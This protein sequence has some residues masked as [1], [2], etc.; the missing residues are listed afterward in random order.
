METM[1]WMEKYL[2]E[3]EGLII[4]GQTDEGLNILNSLLYEE[5]GYGVLHNYLGW[6]YMYFAKDAV[7]AELHFTMAMRF[8]PDYAP[9]F[10]HMGNMLMQAAR[11]NE[12]IATFS[13]GLNKKEALRS[14]LLEGMAQA[15]EMTGAY[16]QAVRKYKEAAQSTMIDFE[17]DRILK[18]VK[19]CRRKRVGMLFSLW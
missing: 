19:R 12:A 14:A 6:A 3:A 13:E 2:Q 9:P 17:V 18:S 10:L 5:P 7:R 16:R 11:Y 1:E 8:S 15:L 4:N